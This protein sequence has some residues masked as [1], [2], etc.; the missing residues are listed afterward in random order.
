MRFLEELKEICPEGS[1][2]IDLVQE[3]MRQSYIFAS[4][5]HLKIQYFNSMEH[6]ELRRADFIGIGF[7]GHDKGKEHIQQNYHKGMQSR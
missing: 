3:K 4:G 2:K 7:G 1:D 6:P 5:P